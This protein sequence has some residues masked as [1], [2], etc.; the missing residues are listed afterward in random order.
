MKLRKGDFVNVVASVDVTSGA[1]EILYV[2]PASS[3][4]ETSGKRSDDFELV[5]LDATGKELARV[6]PIV[7]LPARTPQGG[8]VPPG[9]T[10]LIQEDFPRV[11][12]M[13]TLVLRH[14]GVEKA[15]YKAGSSQAA[16]AQGMNLGP[17]L[18]NRANRRALALGDIQEE[19][20]VTYT[21]QIQPEGSAHWNTVAVGRKVPAVEVDRNQFPGASY[22]KVRVLRSTGFEQDVV[23]EEKVDLGY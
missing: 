4:I 21:V 1:S 16:P 23:S 14:K 2:N 9:T 3:T 19:E 10:G 18:P 22:A 5:A 6:N 7:L 17:A 11:P 13:D 12:G 8:A 15:R 20:G